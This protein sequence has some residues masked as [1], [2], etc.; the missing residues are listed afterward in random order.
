MMRTGLGNE[1]E[2]PPSFLRNM[3]GLLELLV[4]EAAGSAA[5]FTA[6]CGR[7]TVTGTDMRIALMYEAHEFFD[8]LERKEVE[9]RFCSI[10]SRLQREDET[11]SVDD[12]EGG[13]DDDDEEGEGDD[14]PSLDFVRG[15]ESLHAKMR[16]YY[17]EWEGWNPS[18]EMQQM[19]KRAIDAT[20]EVG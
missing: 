2:I 19:L 18:D 15:D 4:E 7:K 14:E 20:T 6:S 9:E 5:T 12:E 8:K 1:R 16:T 17:E 11:E 3:L 13:D 10:V